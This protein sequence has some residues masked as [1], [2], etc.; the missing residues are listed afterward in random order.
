VPDGSDLPNSAKR[1]SALSD[2]ERPRWQGPPP[3]GPG[4]VGV[5]GIFGRVRGLWEGEDGVVDCQ[6]GA[7]VDPD[8]GT[9]DALARLQLAAGRVGRRVRLRHAGGELRE[10]LALLGLD[11]V[12][13]LEE[14][15]LEPEGQPEQREPA[16]GVEEEADPGDPAG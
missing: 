5:P 15:P 12:V 7:L 9:V 6:A 3:P 10:L 1:R 2:P 8:L 13:Q 11:E 4:G 14:L 16:L